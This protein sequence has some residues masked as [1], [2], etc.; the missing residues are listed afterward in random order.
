[1]RDEVLLVMDRLDRT[2]SGRSG[3]FLLLLLLTGGACVGIVYWALQGS[4]IGVVGSALMP[5]SVA[6]SIMATK[7]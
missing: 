7:L 5:G 2:S 4:L 3:L 6:V 1:M